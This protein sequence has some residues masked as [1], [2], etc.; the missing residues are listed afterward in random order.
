MKTRL[1]LINI[2]PTSFPWTCLR[3]V[4]DPALRTLEPWIPMFSLTIKLVTSQVLMP[5]N[6]MLE[7]HLKGAFVAEDSLRSGHSRVQL[8]IVTEWGKTPAEVGLGGEE[9]VEK[10]FFVSVPAVNSESGRRGIAGL[11]WLL[12]PSQLKC[13]LRCNSIPSCKL[14]TSNSRTPLGH[15]SQVS[16]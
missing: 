9:I 3:V 10:E 8:T 7:T 6:L 2:H 16:P 5:R 14:D 12:S 1:P 13:R 4:L 15:H 11:T